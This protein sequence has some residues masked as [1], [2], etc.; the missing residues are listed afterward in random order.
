M[1]S[2]VICVQLCSVHIKFKVG[3][4]ELKH[5]QERMHSGERVYICYHCDKMFFNSESLKMHER[6]HTGEKPITCYQGN[7]S[8]VFS[9]VLRK[10]ERLHDKA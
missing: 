5:C 3:K 1:I 8:F 2:E 7:K 10:V 4:L 6:T 9:V